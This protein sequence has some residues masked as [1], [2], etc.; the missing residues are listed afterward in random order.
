MAEKN[1]NENTK[2]IP[3][4]VLIADARNKLNEV[5]NH[6]LLPP[7]I[8]ELILKEAWQTVAIK[9]QSQLVSDYGKYQEENKDS[10]EQEDNNGL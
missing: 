4:S 10:T 7:S 5:V 3:V 9:A 1:T 8:V 2:S 6:P